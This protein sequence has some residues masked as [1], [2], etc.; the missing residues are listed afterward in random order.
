MY[1][2][3]IWNGKKKKKKQKKQFTKGQESEKEK[4]IMVNPNL[5]RPMITVF[6]RKTNVIIP[7]MLGERR[8]C[9]LI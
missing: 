5:I 1:G 2:Q 6:T 4:Y 7:V 3:L 9:W 8:V